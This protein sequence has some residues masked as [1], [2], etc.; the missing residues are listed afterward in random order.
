MAIGSKFLASSIITK[1]FITGGFFVAM[2]G[3]LPVFGHRMAKRVT[4]LRGDWEYRLGRLSAR[5]I[6]GTLVERDPFFRGV[7]PSEIERA[8]SFLK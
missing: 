5:L 2:V 1:F 4:L 6:K 7:S 3:D 8:I